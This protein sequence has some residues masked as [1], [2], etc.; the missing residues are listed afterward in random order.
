M[1]NQARRVIFQF[2]VG[3]LVSTSCRDLSHRQIAPD[4]IQTNRPVEQDLFIWRVVSPQSEG[5]PPIRFHFAE[6]EDSYAGEFPLVRGWLS[7]NP[8]AIEDNFTGQFDVE[9][10]DVTMGEP[11]LDSNVR[12]N[13]EFLQATAFP[14]SSYVVRSLAANDRRLEEGR[15]VPITMHGTFKLKGVETPLD[16]RATLRRVAK[17]QPERILLSGSFEIERLRDR[18]HISGPGTEDDPAGNQVQVDFNIELAR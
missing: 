2:A 18:F 14:I 6:P 16:V 5:N 12:N 1:T 17:S 7:M 11:D 4:D 9:T 8:D 10:K 3:T 13:V 15:P